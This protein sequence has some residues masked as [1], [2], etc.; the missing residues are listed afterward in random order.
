MNE[1]TVT[2]TGN[3]RAIG[4][5]QLADFLGKTLPLFQPKGIERPTIIVRDVDSGADQG[6]VCPDA[7]G[8]LQKIVDAGRASNISAAIQQHVAAAHRELKSPE[9]LGFAEEMAEQYGFT[10]LDDGA[11]IYGVTRERLTDMMIVLGFG[12]RKLPQAGVAVPPGHALIRVLPGYAKLLAILVEALD[13]A[14]EGKGAERHNLGGDIPFERQR[15]QTISELINSV[16][17]MTYQAVKKITEGVALPTLDRQVRELQGAI[18]YLAGMITFLRK[19]SVEASPIAWA[20]ATHDLS[21][22]PTP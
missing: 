8:L 20:G 15:M 5:T 17:G 11:E 10:T 19:H 2:I 3:D 7:N 16:D 6:A 22:K 13:Q 4:K 21:L 9:E 18:V 14:Q 12:R 1:I